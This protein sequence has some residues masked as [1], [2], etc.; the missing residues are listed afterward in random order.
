M[1]YNWLTILKLILATLAPVGLSASLFAIDKYTKF[2]KLNYWLKQVIFGVLFGSLAILATQFGI[3]VDNAV[4]NVRDA[5]PLVAGLI[6]GGPAGIISGFIGG[7]YR[8]VSTY[9]G[10][11]EFSQ[12]ACSLGCLFAGLAGAGCRKFMFVNHIP[13]WLSGFVLGG[14]TEVF[15]MLLIFITRMNDVDTAY[16]VVSVCFLPMI[17]CVAISASLSVIVVTLIKKESIFD[18]KRS[19]RI[20]HIFQFILMFSVVIA[21]MA[22]T[23]FTYALQTKLA[24]SNAYDLLTLNL[25]DVETDVEETSDNNLLKEAK[26]ISK[27]VSINSTRD[28]LQTLVDFNDVC[29][30]N[31]IDKNGVIIESTNPEFVNFDMASGEQSSDFLDLLGNLEEYVQSYQAI[32]YDS[33]I[34]RKYAGIAFENH[35]GFVQVGYNASQ[36]QTQMYNEIIASVKNRHIGKSGGI[37]VCNVYGEIIFDPGNDIGQILST[38]ELDRL[39]VSD[40]FAN[41]QSTINGTKY[42]CSLTV[43]EGFYIIATLPSSEAMFSRNIAVIV[44]AFMEVVVLSALF[45]HIYIL[46]KRIVVENIRKVNKSLAKITNGDLNVT[47]DVRRT[48]EFSTLSDDI[49]A[50]VDRLKGY[51]SEAEARIDKELEFARQ[52]QHSTLPSVFPPYPERKDFDIYASMNTVK[53]VGGDFYDFY[54]IDKDHLAFLVADVSGKGIPAALFMMRA[55]TTIKSLAESGISGDKVFTLANE[56][57]CENNEAEMFVTAWMG[58]LDLKTGLLKYVNA[59]H[60]PP[61]IA[62]A[63]GNFEYLRTRPNLILAGMDDTTYRLNEIQLKP[64]DCIYLYT[65]GVTEARNVSDA[66][67]GEKRLEEVLSDCKDRNPQSLCRTVEKDL[68]SYALGAEQADDITMLAVKLNHLESRHDLMVHTDHDSITTVIDFIENRMKLFSVPELIANK[69]IIATDE[70]YSNFVYYSK[71]DIST[72]YVKKEDNKRLKLIFTN[73]GIPFDPTKSENPDTTLNAEDRQIGGLGIFIVR[74][75]A[76]EFLYEYK[77]GKNIITICYDFSGEEK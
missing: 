7:L 32:S 66:L 56:R 58:V 62:R 13:S 76:S 64:G 74:K 6:F 57:L 2:N 24:S 48:E 14:T 69:V 63:N 47:V 71:A 5:S 16:N 20:S 28:E 26:K 46:L 68:N 25:L 4:L 51:I 18:K 17:L 60:N 53:E 35:L 41:Y 45:V 22:T 9:W 67:Y 40:D 3:D 31:I 44:L 27:E 43:T 37:I 75:T 10:A 59:G 77:D 8:F 72:V 36:V 12:I 21:F 39:L 65:D 23:L 42:Y 11:G 70:I 30:I 55:K 52:I 49:N 38:D 73:D 50:T 1:T 61:L 29:E 34:Y 54:F 19:K 33:T 15:H